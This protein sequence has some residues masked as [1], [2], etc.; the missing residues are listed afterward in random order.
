MEKGGGET[1]AEAGLLQTF[2]V[3]GCDNLCVIVIVFVF[4]FN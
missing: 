4:V 1:M 3:G 2:C